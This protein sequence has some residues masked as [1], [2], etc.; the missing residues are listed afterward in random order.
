[1]PGHRATYGVY[2]QQVRADRGVLPRTSFC[3]EEDAVLNVVSNL[4]E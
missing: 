4:A 1:M 3:S 2:T